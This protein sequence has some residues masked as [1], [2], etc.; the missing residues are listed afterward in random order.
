MSYSG[1]TFAPSA[2]VLDGG[3]SDDGAVTRYTGVRFHA[4]DWETILGY[5]TGRT[6]VSVTG[7]DGETLA[8]CRIVL[9]QW[10]PDKSFKAVATDLEIWRV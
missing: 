9:R 8:N 2:Q 4:G 3:Y 1:G 5:W 6:L 7:I 10:R